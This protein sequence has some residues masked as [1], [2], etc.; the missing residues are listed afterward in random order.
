MTRPPH[1]PMRKQAAPSNHGPIHEV[2]STKRSSGKAAKSL[3]AV[4]SV[5]LVLGGEDPAHMAPPKPVTGRVHIVVEVG[6]AV[7]DPVVAGPPQRALLYGG[8]PAEGHQELGH[9]AHAVAAMGEVPV[10]A[11]GDEEHPAQVE[12][13]AED[14]VVPGD[15]YEERGQ[16]DEVGA[17]EG[18]RGHPVGPVDGPVHRIGARGACRHGDGVSHGRA[19]PSTDDDRAMVP[20]RSRTSG[21]ASPSTMGTDRST[22]SHTTYASD[23]I[24]V[25][26]GTLDGL[27]R[28]ETP[29]RR[30]PEYAIQCWR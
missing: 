7:M 21:A 19:M 18:N 17:E 29:G 24:E 30:S 9:P 12:H 27:D 1:P 11:G 20:E 26:V 23:D 16:R 28:S 4:R 13:R 14:P 8:G 5:C 10:V 22:S 15:H 25:A 3:M 2:R 6:V